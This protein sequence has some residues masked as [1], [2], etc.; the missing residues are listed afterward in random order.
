MR[1]S[2]DL[3][4]AILEWPELDHFPAT[5]ARKSSNALRRY[6]RNNLN[7]A[8]ESK[9]PPP[10]TGNTLW[11]AR[12][13]NMDS[14]RCRLFTTRPMYFRRLNA[15]AISRTPSA[16]IRPP[17]FFWVRTPI[18]SRRYVARAGDG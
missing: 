10:P 11:R 5:Q 1:L 15:V 9:A 17:R 18:S 7:P 8:M 12:V 16:S 14:D 4:A 13:R 3:S 2:K 6:G